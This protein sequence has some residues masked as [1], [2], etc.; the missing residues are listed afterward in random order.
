MNGAS[1]QTMLWKI[2]AGIIKKILL[3]FDNRNAHD[4]THK[5]EKL[6]SYFFLFLHISFCS[7]T[8]HYVPET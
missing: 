6:G 7:F 3:P 8:D 5:H 4:Y 1:Q 2:K